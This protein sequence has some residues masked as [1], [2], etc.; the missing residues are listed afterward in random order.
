MSTL[1]TTRDYLTPLHLPSSLQRQQVA[2]K[3]THPNGRRERASSLIN[4]YP[5]NKP[6]PQPAKTHKREGQF[7]SPGSPALSD[8]HRLHHEHSSAAGT[9]K[10]RRP[11][12]RADRQHPRQEAAPSDSGALTFSTPPSSPKL[13]PGSR[14][15]PSQPRL[16]AATY[17]GVFSVGGLCL[18]SC[19]DIDQGGISPE[20]AEIGVLLGRG[21]DGP[22]LG[23][24]VAGA[25]GPPRTPR[26]PWRRDGDPPSHPR[27]PHG[28][29]GNGGGG[30]A[31]HHPHGFQS[32]GGGLGP[33]P[34][35]RARG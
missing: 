1:H 7:P 22:H 19:G 20:R 10:L 5:R 17:Q 21:S 25:K 3:K 4:R 2:T 11:A 34:A 8:P 6:Q 9:T 31:H 33:A 30:A 23:P 16:P 27:Y 29:Q 28:F 18:Q 26:F 14:V 13:S 32:W 12:A 24:A 15:S 35:D